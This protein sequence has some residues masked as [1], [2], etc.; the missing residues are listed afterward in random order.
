MWFD[1]LLLAHVVPGI[2]LGMWFGLSRQ[3]GGMAAI[4]L[5][6]GLGP[7]LA[8][9][10]GD[11]LQVEGTIARF[12]LFGLAYAAIALGCLLA[13]RGLRRLFVAARL[14][15]YDRHLGAFLGGAFGLA[16]CAVTTL[17]LMNVF[18]EGR[19]EFRERPSGRLVARAIEG[20]HEAMPADVGR[21]LDPFLPR[22]DVERDHD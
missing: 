14:G 11:R 8:A 3:L 2:L 20:I 19:R 10:L 13:G 18:E 1:M 21:A 16:L 15:G 12:V 4:S 6:F 7:A 17:V 22:P 9:D 5:G